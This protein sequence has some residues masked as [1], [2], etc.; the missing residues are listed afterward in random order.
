[1]AARRPP[2]A[3]R[4]PRGRS[5]VARRHARGGRCGIRARRV[6]SMLSIGSGK[7]A[8]TPAATREPAAVRDSCRTAS[9]GFATSVLVARTLRTRGAWGVRGHHRLDHGSCPSGIAGAWG[10]PAIDLSKRGGPAR[11]RRWLM[12]SG[13]HIGC[14]GVPDRSRGLPHGGDRNCA[15]VMACFLQGT[16]YALASGHGRRW[17]LAPGGSAAVRARRCSRW[18]RVGRGPD[19]A[20]VGLRGVPG[21]GRGNRPVRPPGAWRERRGATSRRILKIGPLRQL[22]VTALALLRRVDVLALGAFG[23]LAQLGPYSVANSIVDLALVLPW[24]APGAALRRELQGGGTTHAATQR[25]RWASWVV[26]PLTVAVLVGWWVIP[27][28][29]GEEFRSAYL[30]VVLLAPGAVALGATRGLLSWRAGRGRADG[31]RATIPP[32]DRP[33]R[34]A[35]GLGGPVGWGL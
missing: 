3:H 6:T 33:S 2:A 26:P 16:T 24:A 8:P 11:P 22:T 5:G 31:D 35:H 28:I 23:T 15:A 20:V 10:R 32:R 14:S 1:M 13:A 12:I 29:W 9:A 34:W 7:L 4:A 30:Y 25:P 17:A 27:W 19:M 21:H 18:T